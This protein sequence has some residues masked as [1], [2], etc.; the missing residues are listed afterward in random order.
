MDINPVR[1][2]RAK[3]SFNFFNGS[4]IEKLHVGVRCLDYVVQ[5]SVVNVQLGSLFKVETMDST[6]RSIFAALDD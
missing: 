5:V 3:R 1:L 6:M 2:K 4:E